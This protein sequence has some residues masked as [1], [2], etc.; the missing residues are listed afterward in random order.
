[1]PWASD[2]CVPIN[3]ATTI[4]A[5]QIETVF[6]SHAKLPY[7]PSRY[8]N[9]HIFVSSPNVDPWLCLDAISRLVVSFELLW[10][11]GG[12]AAS[13]LSGDPMQALLAFLWSEPWMGSPLKFH[14]FFLR[15][16]PVHLSLA[17]P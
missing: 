13:P 12:V 7:R 17:S 16:L 15:P 14:C 5:I 8:A 2:V 10:C 6:I 4:A 3:D 9:E 11:V 1:M